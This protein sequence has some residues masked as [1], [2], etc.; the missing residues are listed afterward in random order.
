MH[1]NL[2]YVKLEL[3]GLLA[4]LLVASP[5]QAEVGRAE[6]IVAS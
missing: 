5:T 1:G 3:I 2:R 4:A 6:P